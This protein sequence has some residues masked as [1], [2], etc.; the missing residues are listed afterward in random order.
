MK[1]PCPDCYLNG[2]IIFRAVV[3]G[4]PIVKKNSKRLVP[5]NGRIVIISSKRFLDWEKSAL[6]QLSVYR[7]LRIDQPV[8]LQ[9]KFYMPTR[10]DVD[11]SNLYTGIE[12]ALV[13]AQ[14]LFDDKAK[15]VTNHNGSG[16]F[17]DKLNPRI[18]IV[19]REAVNADQQ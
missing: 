12:D 3:G 8:N 14:I 1:R 10:R 16:V 5:V 18:E 4:T 2:K 6:N 17:Y 7:K 11:T 9:L 15:I 19:I 13:K